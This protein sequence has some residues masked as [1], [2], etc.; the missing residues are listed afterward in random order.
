MEGIFEP[1]NNSTPNQT[2]KEKNQNLRLNLKR[3]Q[4]H[5]KSKLCY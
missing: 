4:K 5:R 3:E 2:N 1:Q